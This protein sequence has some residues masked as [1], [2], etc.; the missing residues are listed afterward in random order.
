MNSKPLLKIKQKLIKKI[1]K[2]QTDVVNL[3]TDAKKEKK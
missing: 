1:F 2:F 3:L